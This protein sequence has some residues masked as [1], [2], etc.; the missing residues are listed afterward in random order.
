[1]K[2]INYFKKYLPLLMATSLLFIALLINRNLIKPPIVITKQEAAWNLNDKMLQNFHLGFKRLESS[3]LWI[4][5]IIESDVDHYKQKDLNSWMFRRF[6]SISI[7][8]PL[9]YENYSFGGTYLSIVKDDLSGASIIYNRGLEY[10]GDDYNLLRDAGFHFYF[11]AVDYKRAYEV[12]TK[13]KNNPKATPGIIST[14][15]RLEKS[16]GNTEAAFTLLFNKYSQIPDKNSMIA[17]KIH[18]HLYAMKAEIDLTCLNSPQNNSGNCARYD[19]N[20][21]LYINKNGTYIAAS[22]WK[23]FKIKLKFQKD[24]SK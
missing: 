13:L 8:D 10:Y 1:M 19:F 11:E 2:L 23:P 5:T 6:N 21:T 16:Q 22:A 15:A 20:E 7:L 18:Q 24:S 14:L 9:F 4:F 3:F 12:Y 17:Q